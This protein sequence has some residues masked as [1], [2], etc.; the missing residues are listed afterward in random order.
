MDLICYGMRNENGKLTGVVRIGLAP[1]QNRPAVAAVGPDLA[2]YTLYLQRQAAIG[3]SHDDLVAFILWYTRQLRA[4]ILAGNDRRIAH[5][6]AALDPRYLL[7]LD[8]PQALAIEGAELG[9]IEAGSATGRCYIDAGALPAGH[10]KAQ[11][12]PTR[13]VD[14]KGEIRSVYQCGKSILPELVQS[15]ARLI[16]EGQKIASC[17]SL[18]RPALWNMPPGGGPCLHGC[19]NRDWGKKDWDGYSP[20][21]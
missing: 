16:S 11:R 8:D 14:E 6:K 20:D 15:G 3:V 2:G 4:D 12:R 18:E 17:G 19:R 9:I 13:W 7:S 5:G 10:T 1:Y 21:C